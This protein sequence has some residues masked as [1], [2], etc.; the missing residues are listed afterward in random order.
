MGHLSTFTVLAASGALLIGTAFAVGAGSDPVL[1]SATPQSGHVVVALSLG[2]LA[3]GE[4]V[5]ATSPRL[6]AIGAL[7]T[8]IKLREKLNVSST[9]QVVRWRSREALAPGRY[10]VQVSGVDSG[11]ETDCL[12]RQRGCGEDWSNVRRIVLA[13]THR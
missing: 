8:G 3:P 10:F 4:L 6:N 9:A 2:D 12:P 7:T 11:G 1:V 5:V 13:R